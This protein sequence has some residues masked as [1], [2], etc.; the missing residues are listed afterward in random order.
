MEE[1]TT[2]PAS[3]PAAPTPPSAS[4]TP[5]T[6]PPS[7]TSSSSTPPVTKKSSGFKLWAMILIALVV[8]AGAGGVFLLQQKA[9]PTPAD[10]P[11]PSEKKL[12]RIGLS[13]DSVKI[14]RWAD[15]R[16][17]MV[18]KAGALNATITTL[19]AESDDALQIS[20]MENLISQKMDAIIIVAHDA[21]AVG[22]VIT[23][24][25]KA[26]I[27][28]INYDRL[29]RGGTPD[30]YISFDSVKVG[31]IA[32]QYVVDEATKTTTVP[33]IAY[34]AG[35]TTDNNTY[36]VSEGVMKVLDP[37]IKEGKIK[38]V[39]NEFTK[40][41]SPSEAY[42]NFK[43]FLVGGG[44]VDGVIT[45]Y[46]GLAYGAIQALTEYKLDGKVP[47]SGQNG[48]LQ[49]IQ[50]IVKGTQTVTAYKP[51]KPLAER[52]VE[53]AVDFANGRKP[54]VNGSLNNKTAEV[55]AYLFD[56]IPVTKANINDTV[57]KDGTFTTE[58]VFSNTTTP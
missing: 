1:K 51:G 38:L 46:D 50:R 23:K 40:D 8:V 47:V 41:W 45:A 33:N 9:V 25:Q 54:E 11:T 35:S 42:T 57:I 27:K 55:D 26:G 52:A 34:I 19:S 22:P 14:Q 16:D 36:L 6:P 32:A 13:L 12:V 15:E 37:L 24:A 31:Q 18:K 48:E 3:P 53:A 4:T 2:T 49:A 5:A 17:I 21:D 56:P 39:Y 20:Q 10:S 58:Q 7:T 28:V 43:K 44:K 30:L 29:T